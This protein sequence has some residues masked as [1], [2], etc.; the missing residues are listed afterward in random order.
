[1]PI[2][3][4]RFTELYFPENLHSLLQPVHLLIFDITPRPP[5]PINYKSKRE[6]FKK[7]ENAP[8][9]DFFN[10]FTRGHQKLT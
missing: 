5:S 2:C 6:Q 4:Q 10:L 9:S 8:N 7:I 3:V 1:M